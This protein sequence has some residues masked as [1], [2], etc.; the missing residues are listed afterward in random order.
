M[1]GAPISC[2]TTPSFASTRPAI[3]PILIFMPFRSATDL[4]SLR[5]QPPI[6]QPVF[7]ESSAMQPYSLNRG[8]IASEPPPKYHQA[9]F[10][11]SRLFMGD[12]P[13]M[14]SS[15]DYNSGCQAHRSVSRDGHF[16]DENRAA[17][18]RAACERV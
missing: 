17:G 1:S 2:G 9:F 5:N 7:P 4:I 8:A 10:R 16:L 13:W 3:P 14:E 6:W 15:A 11:N 18:A 12:P